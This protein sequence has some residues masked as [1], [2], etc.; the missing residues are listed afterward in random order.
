VSIMDS[1]YYDVGAWPGWAGQSGTTTADGY[2]H[3]G[4]G[5]GFPSWES[6]DKSSQRY[7]T[8]VSL[9]DRFMVTVTVTNGDKADLESLV[10]SMNFSGI[11]SLK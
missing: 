2:V 9:R 4:T 1:A 6:Y 11:A 3:A 8:G 10:N 5:A 7:D